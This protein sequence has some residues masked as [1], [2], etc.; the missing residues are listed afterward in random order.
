MIASHPE[1]HLSPA[2]HTVAFPMCLSG[3]VVSIVRAADGVLV[4][5]SILDSQAY[6]FPNVTFGV[7]TVRGVT[8]QQDGVVTYK[9]WQYAAYYQSFYNGTRNIGRVSVAGLAN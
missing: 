4:S 3:I 7:P 1:T 2:P 5:D 8:F 6:N 9:G